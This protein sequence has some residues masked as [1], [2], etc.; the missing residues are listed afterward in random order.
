MNR[1]EENKD[2]NP[3]PESNPSK[4]MDSKREVEKS[5][6]QKT[7]QDFP[8]YPHYPAKEDMMG[9]ESGSHRVDANL[10][11]MA[12]GANASGVSQRY[13]TGQAV[14]GQEQSTPKAEGESDDLAAINSNN[15]EI[16]IPQNISNEE[17]T[18][19]ENLP[20]SD[21]NDSESGNRDR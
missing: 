14:P 4:P 6:D 13:S 15:D 18:S 12:A 7:D 17:L 8:G 9:L 2:T 16:G 11:E 10:E 21:L 1:N 3:I 20:G 5:P 19:G